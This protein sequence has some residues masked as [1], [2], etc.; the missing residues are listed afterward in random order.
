MAREYPYIAVADNYFCTRCNLLSFIRIF[1]FGYG[2]LHLNAF[3][4]QRKQFP[5]L[6]KTVMESRKNG[7]ADTCDT[8][9]LPVFGHLCIAVHHGYKIFDLHKLTATKYFPADIDPSVISGEIHRIRDASALPFTP[10][11]LEVDPEERWYRE[12]FIPGD[13]SSRKEKSDPASLFRKTIGG[14]LANVILSRPEKK[15]SIDDYLKFIGGSLKQRVLELG[16]D[17]DAYSR[18]IDFTDRVSARLGESARTQVRLAFTHGDFSFVNFI[19]GRKGITVIDWEGADYRNILHDLYNYFFTE[20]YYGRCRSVNNAT[21]TGAIEQLELLL[22]TEEAS[23]VG[24]LAKSADIYRLL[25]YME[26]MQMLVDREASEAQRNVILRSIELFE[27][28]EN[29]AL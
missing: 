8:V 16:E 13:R 26:R 14:Y 7:A 5:V 6:L 17:N 22:T 28:Y 27:N 1:L 25:Y 9:R 2:K 4:I 10:D 12:S 23:H 19:Y 11:L 18:V 24:T 15:K 3:G 29:A 20:L 21:L